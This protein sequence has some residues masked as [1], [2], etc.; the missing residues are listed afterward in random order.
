MYMTSLAKKN[1]N[2][3]TLEKFSNTNTW[4]IVWI[5][6]AVIIIVGLFVVFTDSGDI[7]LNTLLLR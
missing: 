2:K 3:K 6:V 5:L 1:Q 4:T 7:F